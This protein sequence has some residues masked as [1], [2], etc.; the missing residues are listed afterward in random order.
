MKKLMGLVL[1]GVAVFAL[2]GCGGGGDGDESPVNSVNIA[3]LENG[4]GVEFLDDE[5]GAYIEFCNGEFK[6]YEDNT[7]L[8]DSGVVEVVGTTVGLE[9]NVTGESSSLETAGLTPG[10]LQV[11][12][13]YE[14]TE[15]GD[16]FNI[17]VDW[18][19]T[20]PCA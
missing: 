14:V 7:V 9:S 20:I 12:R 11:G 2:S 15:D 4:Y 1:A 6:V 13:T 18:M 10:V 17:E 8:V 16:S 19:D 5:G 3:D